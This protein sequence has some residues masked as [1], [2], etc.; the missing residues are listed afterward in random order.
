MRIEFEMP[1]LDPV[2]FVLD[3]RPTIPQ[4]SHGDEDTVVGDAVAGTKP[5]I[6]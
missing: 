2:A 4:D 6:A 1:I 5:K 3:D